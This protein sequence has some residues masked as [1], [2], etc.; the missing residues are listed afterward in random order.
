[1]T[2]IDGATNA[3]T[4]VFVESGVTSIAVNMV[5]NT[6]YATYYIAP[7]GGVLMAIDGATN[8][9]V[10]VDLDSGAGPNPSAVAVNPVTNKVYVAN[11]VPASPNTVTVMDGATY[12]ITSIPVGV[13]VG[14]FAVNSVTNEI[15]V[16]N[17]ASNSVT[18]IDGATNATADVPTGT[19]PNGI[20]VNPVTN[21]IYALD[22]T[23][24]DVAIID[25]ETNATTIVPV[26]SGPEAIALNPVTN[27]IYVTLGSGM[28]IAIDGATNATTPIIVGTT[29]DA[30]AVN[31]VT[32]TVYVADVSAD[33]VLVTAGSNVVQPGGGSSARLVNIS[34]R[35]MVGTGGNLLIPGFV[36]GGSGTET[37]LIRGDGPSLAQFGVTGALA[38]PVL[39]VFGGDGSIIATN[40]SWGTGV[41]PAQI[42]SIGAQVGAF[43]LSPGS[44]DSALIVNLTPGA[45]TVQIS[46]ANN[47]TGIGLAE[48]Y[49]VSSTGTHLVNI[50]TRAQVG[51]GGNIVIPG[52][53]VAGNGTEELLVRADGP[54]LAEFGVSGFL[55]QPSLSI[56]DNVGATVA[57]NAGWTSADPDL[58]AG[59]ESAVGAFSLTP[60]SADSAQ[61]V[62]LP[63]GAYTMPVS[64]LNSGTGVALAEIYAVP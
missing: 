5:T 6:I 31:P 10:S 20:V 7:G 50:S 28:V 8:S 17:I 21:Q 47:T 29:P 57:S 27:T 24:G 22:V 56:V 46:G 11:R 23:S 49:E 1:V 39:T 59:F 62:D 42:A 4:D 36:V 48:I 53:V 64:G 35:A 34:A 63:A 14:Y 18:V 37:L 55:A 51:T 13:F 12:A 43:A 3:T 58:I 61:V 52:F 2:V 32:G 54:G 33:A 16:T 9:A 45:Y 41:N 44:A 26:G 40:A 60:G 30:I 15:Y 38:Q 25:G 19:N